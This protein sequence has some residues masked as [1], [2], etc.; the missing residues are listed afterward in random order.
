LCSLTPF[1]LGLVTHQTPPPLPPVP[2]PAGIGL[3]APQFCSLFLPPT[4]IPPL[5]LICGQLFPISRGVF[6]SRSGSHSV[7]RAFLFPIPT[8]SSPQSCRN[9]S[10][11]C[12]SLVGFFPLAPHP[13]LCVWLIESNWRFFNQV[14]QSP[15]RLPTGLHS[16]FFSLFYPHPRSNALFNWRF[17][18]SFSVPSTEPLSLL[19]FVCFLRFCSKML[20]FFLSPSVVFFLTHKTGPPPHSLFSVIP[21]QL[22]NRIFAG[23]LKCFGRSAFVREVGAYPSSFLFAPAYF[24]P[25]PSYFGPYLHE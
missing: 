12:F 19:I 10:P 1:D 15:H 2:G 8:F 24:Y 14:I 4:L 22:S 25:P 18:V 7:T 17:P 3:V 5:F 23:A 21:S 11:W 13:R 20:C 16:L 6:N 9:L